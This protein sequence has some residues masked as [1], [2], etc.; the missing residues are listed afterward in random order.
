[1][2]SLYLLLACLFHA[3]IVQTEPFVHNKRNDVTYQ[4][5]STKGA[6]HFLN[7][8]FAHDTA[9]SRR[10]APPEP[11]DPPPGSTVDAT[12]PGPACPQLQDAVPPAFDQVEKIS[13]DC[14]NLRISRPVGTESNDK[15]PVVAWLHGGGIVRGSAYDSHFDP[16]RLIQLSTS[17]G[18]PV[19]FVAIQHRLSIFGF[20]S[21]D[22]LE[23][24][25]STNAGMRDQ[26]AAF[27]WLKSN[28][29]FFG[30][31]PDRI[32]AYGHSSGGTFISLQ[33]FA[34]SGQRG[35]PFDQAWMMS[36]PPGTALNISGYA[37]RTHTRTVAQKLRCRATSDRELLSC[38][39]EVPMADLLQAAME[40]SV[41]NHPPLGLFTFLPTVDNDF[42]PD[43]P[44]V[45]LRRGKFVK[46]WYPV[47]VLGNYE[48]HLCGRGTLDSRVD[49]RR[50][51]HQCRTCSY[52]E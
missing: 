3:S 9:G 10:F 27:E 52:G 21:L 14:L 35:L 47:A 20:A 48:A 34:F 50:R 36:G 25:H 29:A 15:V 31:D 33:H 38:L 8:K 26:R 37:T 18:Q 32:T 7:I 43:R 1:M 42:L 13:E 44:S 46:G 11:F 12:S 39:R 2:P 17:A 24:D 45:L 28:I 30:G 6:E 19:I 40:H 4:G 16:E 23:D 41:A 5:S 49:T 22:V 51:S